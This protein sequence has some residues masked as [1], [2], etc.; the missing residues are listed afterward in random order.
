MNT[1]LVLQLIVLYGLMKLSLSETFVTLVPMGPDRSCII[2]Y[3][4]LS[5]GTCTDLSSY[6]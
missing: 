5:D 6:R 2:G 1:T 4:K 3:S